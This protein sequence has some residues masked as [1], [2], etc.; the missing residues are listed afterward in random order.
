[1]LQILFS[2]SSF[3]SHFPDVAL[4]SNQKKKYVKQL[5]AFNFGVKK[6]QKHFKCAALCT[7]TYNLS[8]STCLLQPELSFMIARSRPQVDK[9]DE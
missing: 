1:M 4:N 6:Q 7:V 8:E 3:L 9:K 5:L 2:K